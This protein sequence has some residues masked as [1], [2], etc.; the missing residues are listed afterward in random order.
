MT[1]AKTMSRLRSI[2]ANFMNTPPPLE[3]PLAYSSRIVRDLDPAHL[4][5]TAG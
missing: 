4:L 5:Q 1:V 3:K 2:V